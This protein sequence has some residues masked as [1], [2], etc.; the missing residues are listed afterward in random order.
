MKRRLLYEKENQ[1]IRGKRKTIAIRRSLES[2]IRILKRYKV[3]E[4]IK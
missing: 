4:N 2:I 1:R 3:R